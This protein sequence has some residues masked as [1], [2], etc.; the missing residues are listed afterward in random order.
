MAFPV[1]PLAAAGIVAL[2]RRRRSAAS[3]LAVLTVFDLAVASLIMDPADA[4]RYALPSLLGVA[5]AAAVGVRGPGAAGGLRAAAR[6]SRPRRPADRG[7]SIAYAWPVLAVRTTDAPPPI[8]GGAL[9][10]AE[11]AGEVGDP[12]GRGHGSR[13]PISCSRRGSTSSRIEDGFHHAAGR[14]D[15]QV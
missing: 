5:F 15:A 11:R 9:G 1:L 12:G 14:P 10:A 8:S 4:V 3:P 7:G 13:R 2:C 6:W